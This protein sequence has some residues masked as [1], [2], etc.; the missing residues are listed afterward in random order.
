MRDGET[1]RIVK[2]D[3]MGRVLF[4][5][6]ARLVLQHSP[7]WLFEAHLVL[8]RS[9]MWVGGLRM[10]NGDR[11]L[12]AYFTDRWYNI[13]ELYEG[14]H[15]P[16]KGWYAN[17]SR[18]ARRL[19]DNRLE[20]VDLHLDLVVHPHGDMVELDREAFEHLDLSPEERRRALQDWERLQRAFRLGYVHLARGMVPPSGEA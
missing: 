16:L 10:E 14:S 4:Q 12:E 3:P 6:S 18:P 2:R 9:P 15:G 11:V 19:P 20:Y 8:P 13:L 5:W 1:W 7:L 17:L